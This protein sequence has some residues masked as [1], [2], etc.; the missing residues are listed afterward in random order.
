MSYAFVANILNINNEGDEWAAKIAHHSTPGA[1][2]HAIILIEL[3]QK[4]QLKNEMIQCTFLL[5]LCS[6]GSDTGA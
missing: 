2:K 1:N 3:G 5:L 4:S 6:K